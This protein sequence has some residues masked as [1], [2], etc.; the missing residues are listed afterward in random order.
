MVYAV[1]AA[2]TAIAMIATYL[3]IPSPQMDN[4]K[5]TGLDEFS[6]TT[7][8]NGRVVPICFGTVELSGN[9]LWY[10]D[11]RSKEIKS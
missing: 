2:I 3:M 6:V 10:G 9:V 1:I 4:A 5:A 11:L 7:N 8:S